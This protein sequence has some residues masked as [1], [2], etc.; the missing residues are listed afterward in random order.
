MAVQ[1]VDV[2]Q[3]SE[4][5]NQT[6]RGLYAAGP[7]YAASFDCLAEGKFTA[8]SPEGKPETISDH[9]V[10]A[11]KTKYPECRPIVVDLLKQLS[12]LSLGRFII[13]RREK[14]TRLVWL[15]DPVTVGKTA[16]GESDAIEFQYGEISSKKMIRYELVLRENMKVSVD[17]S[18]RI[19]S[20]EARRL[21]T[22]MRGC[23]ITST[24]SLRDVA[25]HGHD[26]LRP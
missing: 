20:E 6:V 23:L 25:V 8:V 5:T 19:T 11:L 13:G 9:L 24:P 1:Q 26:Q 16:R 22:F 18:S 2:T 15:A 21:S 10:D 14:L 4:A 3:A 7:V 17:L 12:H